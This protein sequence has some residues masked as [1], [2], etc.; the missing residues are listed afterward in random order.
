MA[1]RGSGGLITGWAQ[2]LSRLSSG[3]TLLTFAPAETPALATSTSG[4]G[5]GGVHAVRFEFSDPLAEQA[6]AT[7]KAELETLQNEVSGYDEKIQ[8]ARD[9]LSARS[10]MSRPDGPREN[11][12]TVM[13]EL[14]RNKSDALRRLKRIESKVKVPFKAISALEVA[15]AGDLK[16]LEATGKDLENTVLVSDGGKV[17][18]RRW[19]GGWETLESIR[20]MMAQV[21]SKAESAEIS[22][23][24]QPATASK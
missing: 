18:A 10:P 12:M 17:I 9:A 19:R 24:P 23:V 14:Q 3:L 8:A 22:I 11:P 5:E 6:L 15:A 1:C 21:G 2:P 4:S 7:L 20:T 16:G 13:N